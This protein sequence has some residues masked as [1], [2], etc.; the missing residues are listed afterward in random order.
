VEVVLVP[1]AEAEEARGEAI[2]Q[3]DSGSST[4]SF[5]RLRLTLR[6]SSRHHRRRWHRLPS[7][8][9]LRNRN[10]LL[11]RLLLLHLRRELRCR[12]RAQAPAALE[13]V[14]PVPA[15]AV[16]LDRALELEPELGQD[17]AQ[18][19]VQARTIRPLPRSFSSRLFQLRL[20]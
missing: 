4:S 3:R 15:L 17:R 19:A 8:L 11:S 2:A 20:H 6:H 10:Q 13:P 16:E 5:G 14:V 18:A 12:V 9:L 7:R 1:P